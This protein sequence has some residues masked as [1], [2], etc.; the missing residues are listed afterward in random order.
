MSYILEALGRGL[1]AHLYG[2][3]ESVLGGN[4]EQ[5]VDTMRRAHVARPDDVDLAIRLGA[6][7]LR[8]DAPGEAKRIFSHVLAR[9]S[10]H[11]PAR[12][13]MACAHD[14]LNEV[15]PAMEHLRLAQKLDP[16]NPAIL[17]CLGYGH[18]RQDDLDQASTYYLDA[19]TICPTLRNSHERL[20][21]IAISRNQPE[22]AIRH[23]QRLVELDPHQIDVHLALANLQHK[24]GKHADAVA[25]FEKALALEPENWTVNQD[26]ARAYEDAGLYR[27]AIEHLHKMVEVEPDQA[28]TRLRLGDLYARIGNDAAAT[29]QYEK[30]AGLSPDYLEANVKLGTQHLRAG[31]FQD[32][33]RWFS[34]GL[35]INDR[36][37]NAYIGIGIAQH[38]QGSRQ[39]ALNSFEM[40]RSIEPNST[41]L[42]SEVARMHLK[43]A[44]AQEAESHFRIPLDG[45][46]GAAADADPLDLV[47]QQIERLRDTLKHSPNHA[48]MHYRLGLLLKNRGQVEDAIESFR[49]A[50]EINPTY[51]KALVKLGLAL[52]DIDRVDEAVEVLSRAMDIKPGYVDLHYQLGLLF[53][54]RHQFE[55]AVE[56]L[57]KAAD[58]RPGN[59][60]FQ[61]NLALALQNMG[62]IDRA[63]ASWQI[64]HDLAPDSEYASRAR[65]ALS[66]SQSKVQKK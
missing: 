59:V 7:L 54:Q 37:L 3:F 64:V 52:R 5:S 39:E 12:V 4:V 10:D 9:N 55:V 21:A 44:A 51:L 29:A 35:E 23:Y 38:A 50:V 22:E 49:A 36:L 60:D 33:A 16:T 6:Q 30:A 46:D 56:H 25:H 8:T 18:E 32:A 40:A 65:T 34:S 61:A 27:E 41:L 24:A 1:I 14:E 31:R 13:G 43:A 15:G 58:A 62:L 2:A 42:F 19:L 53:A 57:E 48:D 17:F 63:T 28:D 45:K 66:R 47:S 20:A 11:L 26:A